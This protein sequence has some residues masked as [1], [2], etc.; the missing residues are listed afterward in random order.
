MMGFSGSFY[1][2]A[3]KGHFKNFVK[4]INSFIYTSYGLG[5][6]GW[7]YLTNQRDVDRFLNWWEE[8]IKDLRGKDFSELSAFECMILYRSVWEKVSTNWWITLLND[9]HLP[10]AYHVT[11]FLM[12]KW[13]H[14]DSPGLMSN[15][16]CGGASFKSVEIMYNGISLSEK[17]KADREL[18]EV[19]KNNSPETI[20]ELLSNDKRFHSFREIFAHHLHY[21]G[22]RGLQELKM[23]RPSLRDRPEQLIVIIKNYLN[24]DLTVEKIISE[25]RER[26]QAGERELN[27]KEKSSW[28]KGILRFQ[29]WRL[30]GF[31]ENRENTRYCRSEL[32]GFSKRIFTR[33]ADHFVK[34]NILE[35]RDDIYFLQ[36]D[37]IFGWIEGAGVTDD[38]K[39]LVKLRRSQFTQHEKEELPMDITTNG[40]V[41]LNALG[42][43]E[44]DNDPSSLRGLGS[45]PGI[46]RGRARVMLD[47]QS[48]D[49]L[50]EGDI[51]IA[52]E[53]DPGWLFLMLASKGMVVERGSMLSHTAITGRKFGIPTIVSVPGVTERIKNGQIIEI[54]GGKGTIKII[55]EI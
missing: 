24:Q 13:G 55:E 22:D 39:S 40:S 12:K 47:P 37:E 30:R 27:L 54:D 11:E 42:V 45:S 7:R 16:L 33:I 17:V 18:H 35:K 41:Y 34:T 28:K 32:F 26:R 31:I 43:P 36:V 19:F 8:T 53:T 6:I 46:V 38:L 23:E 1:I 9:T 52:K 15:L 29:F 4:G 51:L 21:Y 3:D 44:F 10:T 49:K 2:D 5:L 50:E 14:A 25:E 20:I 48:V